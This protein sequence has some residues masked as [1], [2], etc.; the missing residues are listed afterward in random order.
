MLKSDYNIETASREVK[1]AM[2]DRCY[3]QG[4]D[5]ENCASSTFRIYQKCKWC[6]EER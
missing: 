4:H 1:D 5:F 6:G 2:A 3:T